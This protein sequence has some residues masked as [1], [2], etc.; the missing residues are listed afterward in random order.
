[1][2]LQV[3][4]QYQPGSLIE[5][6]SVSKVGVSF[7][8]CKCSLT[9]TDLLSGWNSASSGLQKGGWMIV[10]EFFCSHLCSDI[11]RQFVLANR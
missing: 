10:A 5:V 2:P 8:F 11:Y 3:Y 7:P 4:L 1:M 9:S 6:L